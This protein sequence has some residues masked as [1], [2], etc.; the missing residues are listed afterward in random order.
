MKDSHLPTSN[1][2]KGENLKE[3]FIAEAYQ[4]SGKVESGEKSSNPFAQ[5]KNRSEEESTALS[6]WLQ[7]RKFMH[8]ILPDSTK[9]KRVALLF[10]I[11]TYASILL[12]AGYY[13][14]KALKN[15]LSPQTI[16]TPTPI[17]PATP[18]S[19]TP[20][21]AINQLVA[22]CAEQSK[23]RTA[24]QV[25]LNTPLT[26]FGIYPNNQGK[27]PSLTAGIPPF[28]E[29]GDSQLNSS[30]KACYLGVTPARKALKTFSR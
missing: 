20:V 28:R 2:D 11:V 7:N 27:C 19:N 10:S 3:T 1:G 17:T 30:S 21:S 8:R 14:S 29:I 9:R 12:P 26:K 15:S 23:D 18:P 25:C 6:S 16:T 13:L 5:P 22:E 24:M 4:E